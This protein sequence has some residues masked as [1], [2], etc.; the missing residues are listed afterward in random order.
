MERYTVIDNKTGKRTHYSNLVWNIAWWAVYIL[1][2][3]TA[4]GVITIT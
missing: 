4:I 1:G 3:V 2:A